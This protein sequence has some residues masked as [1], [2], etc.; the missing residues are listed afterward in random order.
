MRKRVEQ[1]RKSVEQLNGAHNTTRQKLALANEE[2]KKLKAENTK[3]KTTMN[4][5]L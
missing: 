3:N 4:E 2:V 5:L 1:Y